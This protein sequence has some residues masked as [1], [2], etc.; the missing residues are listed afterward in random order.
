MRILA[1]R[2]ARERRNAC[3]KMMRTRL[4]LYVGDLYRI[5]SACLSICVADTCCQRTVGLPIGGAI[6]GRQASP[7]TNPH[8]PIGSRA[9][10]TRRPRA[11]RQY[12]S[13]SP[14][15]D[16][17]HLARRSSLV[18]LIRTILIAQ[19]R[20]ATMNSQV[21][22]SASPSAPPETLPRFFHTFSPYAR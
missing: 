10:P 12:L 5:V 3:G 7:A 19:Q 21:P 16:S 15:F 9:S 2:V 6:A 14:S 8:D 13:P 17:S 22:R 1:R 18:P 4:G 20:R 11:S